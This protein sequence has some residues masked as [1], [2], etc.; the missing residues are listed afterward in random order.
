MQAATREEDERGG[1]LE[2]VQEGEPLGLGGWEGAGRMRSRGQVEVK[3]QP[4]NTIGARIGT[5]VVNVGRAVGALEHDTKVDRV[6]RAEGRGMPDN[7][8][9]GEFRE[10]EPHTQEGPLPRGG[11]DAGRV[12]VR[13]DQPAVW[14]S[15]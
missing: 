3:P 8:G 15:G 6:L 7:I 10:I 9:Q 5:A 12:G 4:R 14:V 2:P 11:M 13:Q 1:S